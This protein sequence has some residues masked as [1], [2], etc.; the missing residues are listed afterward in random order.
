MGAWKLY[1]SPAYRVYALTYWQINKNRY[2]T[3]E[4]VQKD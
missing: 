3:Q 2:E 1:R 4:Q